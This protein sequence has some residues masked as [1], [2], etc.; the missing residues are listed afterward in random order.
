MGRSIIERTEPNGSVR[1]VVFDL[2]APIPIT[3]AELRAAEILLGNNLKDLLAD[4]SKRP[5]KRR[6]GR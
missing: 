4:T 3:E 2:P 5:L 6:S 1:Q